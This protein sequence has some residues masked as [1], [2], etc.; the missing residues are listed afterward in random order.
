M[1]ERKKIHMKCISWGQAYHQNQ[2][3]VT[4][5]ENGKGADTIATKK[6]QQVR[7]P[8]SKA[9]CMQNASASRGAHLAQRATEGAGCVLTWLR[10]YIESPVHAFYLSLSKGLFRVR[11]CACPTS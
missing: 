7:K 3:I 6:S 9:P 10:L 2:M 11:T 1:R 4:V 5:R 8:D